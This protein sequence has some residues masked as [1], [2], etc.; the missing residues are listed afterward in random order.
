[1]VCGDE[2]VWFRGSTVSLNPGHN[3]E[4][5]KHSERASTPPPAHPNRQVYSRK[6]HS[7][8]DSGLWLFVQLRIL[9]Q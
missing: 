4:N 3:N 7:F 2:F 1:M 6:H 5:H 8:V 9:I